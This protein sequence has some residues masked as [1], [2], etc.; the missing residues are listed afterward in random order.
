MQYCHVLPQNLAARILP[1]PVK[2]RIYLPAIHLPKQIIIFSLLT[3][4]FAMEFYYLKRS[5]AI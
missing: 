3:I 2:G 1:V 5:G 4:L